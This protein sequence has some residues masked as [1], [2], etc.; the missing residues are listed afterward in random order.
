MLRAAATLAKIALLGGRGWP[1]DEWGKKV[2]EVVERACK[3]LEPLLEQAGMGTE[4][5]DAP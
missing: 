5:P 2:Y 3:E 4:K 1:G